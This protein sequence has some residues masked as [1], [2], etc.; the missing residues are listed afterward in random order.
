MKNLKMRF[1]AFS[2]MAL[3]A[4]SLFMTSCEQEAVPTPELPDEM[5]EQMSVV[6]SE[7][8][9]E[10]DVRVAELKTIVDSEVTYEGTPHFDMVT[11]AEYSTPGATAMI[12]PVITEGDL[13]MNWLINYFEDGEYKNSIFFEFTPTEEYAQK[14]IEDPTIEYSGEFAIYTRSR[15]QLVRSVVE[16]GVAVETYENTELRCTS[17]SAC[18]GWYI[19]TYV[20]WQAQWAC[21][22][23]LG[24]CITSTIVYVG[25]LG[26]AAPAGVAALATCGVVIGCIGYS[27]WHCLDICY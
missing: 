27:F 14:V 9:P 8:L 24:G 22:A 12:L 13:R 11:F 2:L 7:V 3:F 21:A 17:M 10:S 25:S 18:V 4:L 26:S 23:S 16:K 15:E 20:P 19:R 1:T 5:F 6:S